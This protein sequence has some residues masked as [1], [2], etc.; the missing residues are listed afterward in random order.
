MQKNVSIEGTVEMETDSK[1]MIPS[2]NVEVP[3]L[4]ESKDIISD[5]ALLSIYDEIL[6]KVREDR[7]EI[8]EVL[9]QFINMVVNDGDSS[10]GSKEALTSLMKIKAD[11]TDKMANIA[12]LMTMVKMKDRLSP[13]GP[14]LN[15]SQTNNINIGNGQKRAILEAINKA[16]KNEK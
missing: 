11:Q 14:W 3:A 2:M 5:D 12:K 7:N 1:S 13:G 10:N 16:K 15:A 8:N 9:S 6:G 4:Q